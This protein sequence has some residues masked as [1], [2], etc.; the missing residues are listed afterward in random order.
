MVIQQ[1]QQQHPANEVAGHALQVCAWELVVG[2]RGAVQVEGCRQQQQLE[3]ETGRNLT[4]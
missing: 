4:R 1:Q 3:P 2:Y